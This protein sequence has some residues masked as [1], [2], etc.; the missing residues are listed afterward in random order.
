MDNAGEH[1]EYSGYNEYSNLLTLRTTAWLWMVFRDAKTG[2]RD[3][4]CNLVEHAEDANAVR[5]VTPNGVAQR[6]PTRH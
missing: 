6:F 1:V 3:T 2:H 5:R 4:H